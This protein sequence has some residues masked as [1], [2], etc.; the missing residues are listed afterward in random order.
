MR[1]QKFFR[2][3]IAVLLSKIVFLLCV[4]PYGSVEAKKK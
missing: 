1:E 2:R 4:M 3:D